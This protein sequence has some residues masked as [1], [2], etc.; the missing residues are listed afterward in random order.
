M[1]SEEIISVF[2]LWVLFIYLIICST[3]TVI[4]DFKDKYYISIFIISVLNIVLSIAV[5]YVTGFWLG[6]W[7]VVTIKN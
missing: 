2:C 3:V 6:W 4:N 5:I 7:E 1:I